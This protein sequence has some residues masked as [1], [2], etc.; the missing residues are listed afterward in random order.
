MSKRGDLLKA[1]AA[2]V[3]VGGAFF[4]AFPEAAS[5]LGIALAAFWTLIGLLAWAAQ[6][7]VLNYFRK[8]TIA[9]LVASALWLHSLFEGVVTGL[10]F[11]ISLTFGYVVAGA[12]ILHLLP[13]FLAAIALLRGTGTQMRTSLWI[14][15]TTYLFLFAG[16]IYTYNFLPHL[17]AVL[18]AAIA[19]TAGAFLYIGFLGIARRYT[20]QNLLGFV[21]GL[22]IILVYNKF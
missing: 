20:L 15:F 1:V 3:F 4:D 11:G 21:I 9:P 17:G 12:M 22:I 16:F 7:Q 19:I 18:P 8:L 2:G 6:K 10:S 14:I 13:E 5:S